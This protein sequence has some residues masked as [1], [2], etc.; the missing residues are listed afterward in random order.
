MEWKFPLRSSWHAVISFDSIAQ[1]S[2]WDFKIRPV[3]EFLVAIS[4]SKL[5]MLFIADSIST[6]TVRVSPFTTYKGDIIA[7]K[8]FV[9]FYLHSEI[10]IWQHLRLARELGQA[11]FY[12]C[13]HFCEAVNFS[14]SLLLC[15]TLPDVDVYSKYV[16]LLHH[17]R[18]HSVRSL[19][20]EASGIE[21][22]IFS[23]QVDL[24]LN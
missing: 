12:H 6:G 16:Y 9:I 4:N 14:L 18:F 8:N 20:F 21:R 23:I 19:V 15:P 24:Y 1:R 2:F 10:E 11:D 13:A 3:L 17:T 5:D 22:A 7:K